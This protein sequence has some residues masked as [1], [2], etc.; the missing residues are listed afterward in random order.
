MGRTSELIGKGVVVALT[1]AAFVGESSSGPENN[2]VAKAAG[3]IMGT[4]VN[5]ENAQ[6]IPV[7]V[8]GYRDPHDLTKT[9]N[10]WHP[11]GARLPFVC[12]EI[13]RLGVDVDVPGPDPVQW[14]VWYEVAGGNDGKPQWLPQPYVHPDTALA[15]C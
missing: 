14:S 10:G 5:T 4:V 15:R 13:G 12:F 3:A 2:S 6:G 11:E 7:G 9:E 1:A 8:I